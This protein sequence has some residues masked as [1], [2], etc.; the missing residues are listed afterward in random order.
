MG[1]V[2]AAVMIGLASAQA[3]ADDQPATFCSASPLVEV[4]TGSGSIASPCIIAPSTFVFESQYYQNASLV[5]G[6]ALAAYPLLEVR[7]GISPRIEVDLSPPSQ[8][9]SSAFGGNEVNPLSRFGYELRY[10]LM[11]NTRI[12]WSVG[13]G[14]V[15]PISAYATDPTQAKYLLT[16]TDAYRLT[17]RIVVKAEIAAT[18]AHAAGFGTLLPVTALGVDFTPATNTRLSVDIGS[19]LVGRRAGAQSF[20]DI[21]ISHVVFRRFVINAGLGTAFN[22]VSNAKAHYLSTGLAFRP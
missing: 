21:G 1:V 7:A 19:R 22:S 13:F 12:A 8:I 18:T 20:S 16:M 9:A 15:P 3:V 17:R 5:G 10:M 4:T 2:C 11:Q 14:A 6:T